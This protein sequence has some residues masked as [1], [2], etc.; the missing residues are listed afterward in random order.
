MPIDP[1]TPPALPFAHP[2]SNP[3]NKAT[4]LCPVHQNQLSVCG[5][6]GDDDYPGGPCRPPMVFNGVDGVQTEEPFAAHI[7]LTISVKAAWLQSRPRKSVEIIHQ[8]FP[9]LVRHM[10]DLEDMMRLVGGFMFDAGYTP[11]FAD[12]AYPTW[13][14]LEGVQ[15]LP[16]PVA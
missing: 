8:I 1:Q 15:P 14:W 7:A 10:S 12:P 2:E 11:L 16:P 5:Q 4:A 13:H 6:S 3:A 9:G